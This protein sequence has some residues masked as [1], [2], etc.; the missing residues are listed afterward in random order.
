M[1]TKSAQR[2][3]DLLKPSPTPAEHPEQTAPARPTDVTHFPAP[4]A[5]AQGRRESGVA[6][7]LRTSSDIGESLGNNGGRYVTLP[8]QPH[9]QLR[10]K[11]P[12]DM[13]ME[14][15]EGCFGN[16]PSAFTEDAMVLPN[17]HESAR[18]GNMVYHW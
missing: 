1:V 9:F 12:A 11:R 10:R 2:H 6:S 7:I 14:A 3:Q 17:S 15:L 4:P 16:V 5:T 18:C 13:W 8:L